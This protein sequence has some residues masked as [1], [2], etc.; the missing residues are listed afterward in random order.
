MVAKRD[1]YCRECDG[2]GGWYDWM[3]DWKDCSEC[4]GTGRVSVQADASTSD[5]SSPLPLAA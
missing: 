4:E 1:S 5:S 3:G 2:N